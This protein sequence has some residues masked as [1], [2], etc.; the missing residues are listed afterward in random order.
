MFH[1]RQT[2]HPNTKRCLIP[3]GQLITYK[4]YTFS[5]KLKTMISTLVPRS[6][7]TLTPSSRSH[8]T[9]T[10][11]YATFGTWIEQEPCGLT[12]FASISKIYQN[13]ARKSAEWAKSIAE[14]SR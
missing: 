9:L 1:S 5:P 13:V 12:P 11:R 6:Q 2:V 3:G 10:R 7:H 4:K 8:R 14:R